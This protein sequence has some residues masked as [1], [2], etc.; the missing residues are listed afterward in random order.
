[1]LCTLHRHV[2]LS[3]P[4]Y[5]NKIHSFIHS[6]I[7]TPWTTQEE[8]DIL[9][10]ETHLL[11]DSGYRDPL[12]QKV[13]KPHSVNSLLIVVYNLYYKVKINMNGKCNFMRIH[14]VVKPKST[15]GAVR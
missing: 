6:F 11:L 14:Q 2:G 9:Q 15:S 7:H 8:V 4:F 1:M 3:R 10:A 12:E 13:I 5:V